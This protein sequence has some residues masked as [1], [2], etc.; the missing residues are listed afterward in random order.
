MKQF[1]SKI[2]MVFII[3][4]TC[5]K[6]W[7]QT[8]LEPGDIAVLWYQAD[9]PDN[10]AFV[11]FVD[12]AAGTGIYFTDCR[13]TTAADGFRIPACTEGVEKY[14]VPTGG[15]E[16]GKIVKFDGNPNFTPYNDA[17]ITGSLGLATSGDH[18]VVFQD[19]TSAG[20]GSNAANNP[21]YIFVIHSASTQFAGNPQDSNETSLPFGLT[22]IGLPRTALGVGAGPGVDEEFDNIGGRT[23]VP[24]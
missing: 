3:I 5:S 8:T 17:R 12:L 14:T 16:A 21:T 22:D 24:I 19:A 23:S 13:T 1:Y 6:A 9:T 11:T 10:F 20:G 18:V 4:G 2:L 15:H 7:S